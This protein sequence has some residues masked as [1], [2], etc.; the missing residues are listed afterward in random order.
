MSRISPIKECGNSLL[1]ATVAILADINLYAATV[2]ELIKIFISKDSPNASV[3]ELKAGFINYAFKIYSNAYAS[4][5][6]LRSQASWK[7][8]ESG[9]ELAHSIDACSGMTPSHNDFCVL[10]NLIIAL[11]LL[12]IVIV[13][14]YHGPHRLSICLHVD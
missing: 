9:S 4:R 5:T 1:C 6:I 10:L 11:L 8:V 12:F 14:A 2:V 13:F 3:G 7:R